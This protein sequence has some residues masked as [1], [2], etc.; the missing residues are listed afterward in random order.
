MRPVL[1]GVNGVL[2]VTSAFLRHDFGYGGIVHI[3]P[4]MYVCKGFITNYSARFPANLS[5][6]TLKSSR[7]RRNARPAALIIKG[8]YHAK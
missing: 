4:H 2:D 8:Y 1:D 5:P 6:T 3:L 7:W